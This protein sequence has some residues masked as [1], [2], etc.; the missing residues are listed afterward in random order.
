MINSLGPFGSALVTIMQQVIMEV[1]KFGGAYAEAKGEKASG[2]NDLDILQ[3]AH[4][5]YTKLYKRKFGLEYAWNV[6]RFEQKWINLEPMNPTPKTTSSNKRK[7][8][9]AAP[10]SGSIVGEHE[11]R[12]AGIKAMKKSRN[13]GKEKA[14]PSQEFEE[15]P[16][17]KPKRDATFRNGLSPLQQCTAAIRLLA[18]RTG[19]DS[20]DEY[21]RLAECTARKCLEHFVV[22]IVDLF[23]TE[24]LRRPTPEDLQRLLFY[25]EQ[26]GFPGMVGSIDCMHWKWK[27]CPTAWK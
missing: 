16:Y 18:Y 6:I 14:A 20:V 11:S 19:S 24:S 7:A 3:N 27:N 8:D 17:F 21:I 25:G 9:D 22:G 26:R 13:K 12:P 1:S 23:G 2:M 5:L 10:S 4:Q 15:V